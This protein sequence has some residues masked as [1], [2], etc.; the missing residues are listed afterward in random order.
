ME[1]IVEVVV[2]V[3]VEVVVQVVVEEPEDMILGVE[4]EVLVVPCAG[5]GWISTVVS[6]VISSVFFC[7]RCNRC[8][9]HF[10]TY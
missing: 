5:T 9:N 3:V 4:V 8:W 6:W 10:R 7:C 1:P 2:V